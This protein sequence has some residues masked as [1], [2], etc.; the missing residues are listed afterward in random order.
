MAYFGALLPIF[1]K[2][3]RILGAHWR[4][5]GGIFGIFLH[6]KNGANFEQIFGSIFLNSQGGAVTNAAAAR[7]CLG[8]HWHAFGVRMLHLCPS[9]EIVQI[10]SPEQSYEIL[11][12]LFE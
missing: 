7:A 11:E 1:D 3:W 9:L 10:C 4:P 2:F 6:T 12:V 5:R 8:T